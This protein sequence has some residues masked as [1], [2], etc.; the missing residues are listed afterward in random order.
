MLQWRPSLAQCMEGD[1]STA[2]RPLLLATDGTVQA[3]RL[4]P[5]PAPSAAGKKRQVHSALQ[6]GLEGTALLPPPLPPQPAPSA[7]GVYTE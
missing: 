3:L 4:F 1:W 2:G 5:F 6:L 7:H